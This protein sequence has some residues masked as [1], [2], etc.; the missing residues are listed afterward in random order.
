MK[1]CESGR[2]C[3]SHQSFFAL[4]SAISFVLHCA[5][6]SSGTPCSSHHQPSWLWPA[7]SVAPPDFAAAL[8]FDDL[9][10][11]ATESPTAAI[12]L[13]ASSFLIIITNSFQTNLI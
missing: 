3:F 1:H 12:T 11:A 10:H 5:H 6:T 2:L 8:S 13:M 7:T 9:L 4:K